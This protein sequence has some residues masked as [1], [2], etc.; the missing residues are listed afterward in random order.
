[1]H[2]GDF[3]QGNWTSEGQKNSPNV[4]HRE[5]NR[6]GSLMYVFQF[7]ILCSIHDP[8]FFLS[9]SSRWISQTQTSPLGKYDISNDDAH[10]QGL[11]VLGSG[12]H[13]LPPFAGKS[14]RWFWCVSELDSQYLQLM[15]WPGGKRGSWYHEGYNLKMA[16][17]DLAFPQSQLCGLSCGQKQQYYRVMLPS[18]LYSSSFF[19]FFGTCQLLSPVTIWTLCHQTLWLHQ[20]SM[21]TRWVDFFFF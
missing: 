18:C 6:T 4:T 17:G 20:T 14:S 11:N 3:R 16:E 5:M 2:H 19:I 15:L 9:L 1:M 8:N 7:Q 10:H 12:P 13:A 21:V